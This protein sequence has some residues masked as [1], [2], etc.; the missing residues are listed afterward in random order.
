[1]PKHP[2][3]PLLNLLTELRLQIYSYVVPKVPRSQVRTMYS[4]L[5][6]SCKTI[7]DEI[8][9]TILRIMYNVLAGIAQVSL[10]G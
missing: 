3:C 10:E 2:F 1:M 7:R 4:G 5:V 9:P 8:E 6:L